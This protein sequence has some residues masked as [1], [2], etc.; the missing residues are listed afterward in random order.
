MTRIDP[1]EWHE[2]WRETFAFTERALVEM[3]DNVEIESCCTE[4]IYMAVDDPN[5][6]KADEAVALYNRMCRELRR[7]AEDEM[8]EAQDVMDEDSCDVE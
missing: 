7:T 5:G 3:R 8:K 4:L 6:L 2:S 1:T